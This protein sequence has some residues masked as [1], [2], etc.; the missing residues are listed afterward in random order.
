MMYINKMEIETLKSI[1]EA[2][3]PLDD[4][5]EQWEQSW[6]AIEEFLDELHISR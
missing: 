2:L 3:L 4:I 5:N 1:S 6:K